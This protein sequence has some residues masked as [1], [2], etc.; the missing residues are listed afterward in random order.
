MKG[1]PR[2]VRPCRLVSNGGGG[3]GGSRRQQRQLS[4]LLCARRAPDTALQSISPFVLKGGCM[5]EGYSAN[6]RGNATEMR[7]LPTFAGS[8]R[9]TTQE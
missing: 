1:L 7:R 2:V 4:C 3:S 9:G 5:Q 8:S 6:E